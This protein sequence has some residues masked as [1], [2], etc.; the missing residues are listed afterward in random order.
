MEPSNET[1]QEVKTFLEKEQG[2]ELSWEEATEAASLVN[3]LALV[4]FKNYMEDF[5]REE[6]LKEFP[7][8]FHLERSGHACAIC[9]CSMSTENSW[10]DK[11]GIKCMT[12]Q[13]AIDKKIIPAS[14][15]KNRESW[16]SKYDL[17]TYFNIKA[18]V[19]RKWIN[20]NILKARTVLGKGNAVYL[21]LFLIKENKEMLPPKKFL[22][23]HTFLEIRDDGKQGFILMPWYNFVDP[24]KHLKEY[25]I[26]DYIRATFEK[27]P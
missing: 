6:K 2:R 5:R 25:K 22:K 8:G 4:V 24:Y 7:K 21:Q 13:N 14:V 18:P 9:E 12:C 16:Y 26:M 20:Q 27:W 1:I 11:Y 3:N 10:Y 15:A 19:L 17:E 23:D